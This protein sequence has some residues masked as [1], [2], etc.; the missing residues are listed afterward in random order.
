MSINVNAGSDG[1]DIR[2]KATWR[3]MIALAGAIGTLLTTPEII[4]LLQLLR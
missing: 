3:T 2:I 1:L 4:H